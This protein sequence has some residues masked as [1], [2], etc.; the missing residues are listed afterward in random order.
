MNKEIQKTRKNKK[1]YFTR[2][3]Q[4]KQKQKH[5]KQTREE[6][7]REKWQKKK[8][9]KMSFPRLKKHGETKKENKWIE[10]EQ[11]GGNKE[12]T[13]TIKKGEML[14]WRRNTP[15]LS[16]SLKKKET[17]KNGNY[18]EKHGFFK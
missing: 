17:A 11:K 18:S 14:N 9:Q 5:N 1:D 7:E 8:K 4:K 2:F 10:D 6:K 12:A 3:C 15:F 16:L 13:Q